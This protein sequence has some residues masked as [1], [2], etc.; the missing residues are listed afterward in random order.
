M[1]K[2]GMPVSID[3]QG[4]TF[5]PD[6]SLEQVE[7]TAGIFMFAEKGERNGP[8]SIIHRQEQGEPWSSTF[9]PIVIAAIHLNQHS[10]LWHPFP[11][12]AMARGPAMAWTSQPGVHQY[13][14]HRGTCQRYTIPLLK[15]LRHMGVVEVSVACTCQHD[16]PLPEFFRNSVGQIGDPDYH[17]TTQRHHP[18]YMPPRFAMCGV[19]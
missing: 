7:I 12:Q 13:L 4:N 3:C 1:L 15:H 14:A 9:Q 10:F 18:F 11:P 17:G 5:A 6:D 8:G 19:R 2:D 16:H